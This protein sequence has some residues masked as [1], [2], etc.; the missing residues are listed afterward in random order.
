[1][2]E[3]KSPANSANSTCAQQSVLAPGLAQESVLGPE[4]AQETVLAPEA[5]AATGARALPWRELGAIAIAVAAFMM[6]AVL[7]LPPRYV[8]VDDSFL[9]T[10]AAGVA[11][12]AQPDSHIP[13]MNFLVGILLSSLYKLTDKVPFYPLFLLSGQYIANVVICGTMWTIYRDRIALIPI[14]LYLLSIAMPV[15]T[16]FQFSTTSAIIGIAGGIITGAGFETENKQRRTSAIVAGIALFVLSILTR[17]R[18]GIIIIASFFVVMVSKYAFVRSKKLIA[19]TALTAGLLAVQFGLSAVNDMYYAGRWSEFGKMVNNMYP[20]FDWGRAN[21][22]DN[23]TQ[24]NAVG[25]SRNDYRMMRQGLVFDNKIFSSAT[26]AQLASVCPPYRGDWRTQVPIN[27]LAVK[28]DAVVSMLLILTLSSGLMLNLKQISPQRIVSLVVGTIAL[29]FAIAFLFKL[30][31]HA[32]LPMFYI[33][34]VVALTHLDMKL[35]KTTPLRGWISKCVTLF[36]CAMFVHIFINFYNVEMAYCKWDQR[37]ERQFH[38]LM[39]YLRSH[40]DKLVFSMHATGILPPQI[41]SPFQTNEAL[42]GIKLVTSFSSHAPIGEDIMQAN[43][44]KDFAS[45]LLAPNS[46]FLS[47]RSSNRLL[48]KYFKEHHGLNVQFIG[49][50]VEQQSGLGVY[51]VAVRN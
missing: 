15:L 13:Y 8:T 39:S 31:R 24:L 28:R 45:G 29:T 40:P 38:G 11:I 33:L 26:F 18:M 6:T 14:G 10:I 23:Q 7:I 16:I 4:L 21:S 22:P 5:L 35:V 47:N 34:A 12:A 48:K 3:S 27:L 37:A 36:L 44:V 49:L 1:M 32:Y 19:V 2:V 51:K 9:D 20:I 17:P 43:G 41:G 25:W 30:A 42:R 46:V 50:H